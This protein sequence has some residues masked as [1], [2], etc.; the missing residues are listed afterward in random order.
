VLSTLTAQD[1]ALYAISYDDQTVLAGFAERYGIGYPLLS[2]FGSPVMRQLG[3]LN[4]EAPEQIAG[5]PHPGLFVLDEHGVIV[6]KR[7]YDSY[8]ERDT[9]TGLIAELLGLAHP[10]HGSEA[11]QMT[12]VVT[13]HA[14]FDAPSY[15]WGQRLLLTVELTIAPG[16]HIYGTPIPDGYVPLALSVAP[17]ERVL[18]GAPQLPQPHPFQVEGLDERFWVYEGTVRLTLPVT[19][20]VVDAGEQQVAVTV[21]FQVCSDH[22]CLVPETHALALRLPE[23]P[24]LERP[25]PR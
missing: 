8:R 13:V 2:D 11:S 3:L 4:A 16:Y 7:F 21:A 15:R 20:M 5:I 9:A 17:L 12:D 1:I 24:L 19:F 18:V 6:A 25:Q 14:W 23:A 10:E 22:D